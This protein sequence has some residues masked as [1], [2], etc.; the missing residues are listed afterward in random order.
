[1][2]VGEP[3]ERRHQY[4][5]RKEIMAKFGIS[6]GTFTTYKNLF[7]SQFD[8]GVVIPDLNDH[9]IARKGP[10]SELTP[11]LAD[12]LMEFNSMEGYQLTT[13]LFTHQF[14]TIYGTNY[15]ESTIRKYLKKL[16]FAMKNV[17]VKP[18]L[19]KAQILRRLD[20]VLNKIE[21][22]PG[23]GY[24]FK[25]CLNV[26]HVDE[27]WFYT[28]RT[29][30]RIRVYPGEEHHD[31]PTVQH[32]SH[33]PKL[34]FLAAVGVPQQRPDGT[35]FDGKICIVPIAETVFAKR[36][37]KNRPAGAEVIECLSLTAEEYLHFMGE[38]VIPA[39]RE[40]MYWLQV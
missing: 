23:G 32:K 28:L 17:Y 16:N 33:I 7:F 25:S 38:Y 40:K 8:A 3:P 18:S 5:A 24:R 31:A 30:K 19:S 4:G 27:K 2:R 9:E 6:H 15:A 14:N 34:M 21:Q 20:F 11:E 39:I 36:S 10:K 22:L 12:C 13:D 37:S 29:H 1:M 26:V 35:F